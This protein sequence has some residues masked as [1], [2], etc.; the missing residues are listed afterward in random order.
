[1]KQKQAGRPP[2]WDCEIVPM[3]RRVPKQKVEEIDQAI[4]KICEELKTK[5]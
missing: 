5:K 1:M 4:E 2:K 3:L